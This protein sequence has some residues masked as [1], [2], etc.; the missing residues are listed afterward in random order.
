MEASLEKLGPF[1][2]EFQLRL[3]FRSAMSIVLEVVDAFGSR[4][5]LGRLFGIQGPEMRGRIRSA[6]GCAMNEAHPCSRNAIVADFL[7]LAL[8]G[9]NLARLV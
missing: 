6:R 3:P 5:S 2:L 8:G 4:W 7:E 1:E 9:F